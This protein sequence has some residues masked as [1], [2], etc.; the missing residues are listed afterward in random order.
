MNEGIYS[1]QV[2]VTSKG[3]ERNYVRSYEVHSLLIAD[4]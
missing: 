2:A 4:C 1:Q 3:Q